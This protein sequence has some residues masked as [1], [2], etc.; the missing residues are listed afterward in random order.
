MNNYFPTMWD[1]FDYAEFKCKSLGIT[2]GEL[3]QYLFTGGMS[4]GES[5]SRSFEIDYL[6]GRK[7]KKGFHMTLFRKENSYEMVSY[8][9]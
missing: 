5:W 7:T 9:L 8:V 2:S 1:A 4:I 3:R 6:K